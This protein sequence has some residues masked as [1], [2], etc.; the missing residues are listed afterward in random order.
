VTTRDN[1]GDAS[2][3]DPTLAP[4][5]GMGVQPGGRANPAEKDDGA[6][7]LGVF[8]VGTAGKRRRFSSST[9]LLACAAVVAGGTL[10]AM[11]R[12]GLGPRSAQAMPAIDKDLERIAA[13]NKRDHTPLLADLN[14]TRTAMQVPDAKVKKNPFRLNTEAAAAETPED[15][16]IRQLAEIARAEVERVKREAAARRQKIEAALSNLKL[17][18]VGTGSVPLAR[19]SGRFYRVG[20]T[21]DKLFKVV[22]VTGRTAE[23]ECDGERYTLE[24]AEGESQP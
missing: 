8:E 6:S 13:S 19:I 15:P 7:T 11:R 5:A 17:T 12:V 2:Q 14:A 24:I 23:L 3:L 18:G 1:A 4:L 16:T 21:V 10:Y 20:D 22:A 9:V